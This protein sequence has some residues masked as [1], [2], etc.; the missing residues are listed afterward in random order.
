[1]I[2]CVDVDYRGEEAVAA[3]ALIAQ[4]D[5]ATPARESVV[6]IAG[7]SAEYL[8]GEF[9]RRELPCIIEVLRTVRDVDVVVIDGYV[10]LARERPGL[11]ARLFDV[12]GGTVAVV[13]VAKTAFRD[14]D[15]AVE[16][17]RGE[18]SRPLFVTARGIDVAVAA[19]R[20][21]TMHGAHR[22]P[23]ILARVDRLARDA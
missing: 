3:A 21:R 13:G 8:P 5:D 10:W 16:V 1:M 6:R 9:Y 18:S 7:T 14:N 2:A 20:V 19:D 11:G 4:F 23:T 15:A 12:L 17:L 22:I